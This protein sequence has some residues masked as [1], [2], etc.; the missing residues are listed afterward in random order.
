MGKLAA[1]AECELFDLWHTKI[2]NVAT[3]WEL[4]SLIGEQCFDATANDEATRVISG[5]TPN[6]DMG[7]VA[8]SATCEQLYQWHT[9]IDNVATEWERLNAVGEQCANGSCPPIRIAVKFKAGA[10]LAGTVK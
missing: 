2:D 4:L 7:K 8:P 6:S 3:E 10:D 5:T 1:S 9:K